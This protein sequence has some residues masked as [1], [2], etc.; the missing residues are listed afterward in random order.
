MKAKITI[1]LIVFAQFVFGQSEFKIEPF[2][3]HDKPFIEVTGT[4]TQEIVPDKIF[5]SITLTNKVIEK[6]TYTIQSQE[7]K[8]KSALTRNS[9]NLK[10]L[11]LNDI[12]SEILTNKKKDIGF[13]VKKTF[14]LLLSSAEQVSKIS[15][16][17]Q[18]INI[19]EVSVVKL[20][21]S[22]IDSL[23]K[24]VRVLAIKAA[25]AKAEYLLKA[26]DEQLG[27][28]LEIKEITDE[29]YYRDNRTVN[30][31]ILSNVSNGTYTSENDKDEQTDFDKIRISFSYYVKYSIK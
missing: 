4:A 20:D 3:T 31:S 18:T 29:P 8:L 28:P 26:I 13:E 16:E 15:K 14:T 19:K 23:R 22:K 21:H 9:I 11:T 24:E 25:K 5:V 7:E 6:Q 1:I 27:K 12:N 2:T 10:F 17:L 30:T